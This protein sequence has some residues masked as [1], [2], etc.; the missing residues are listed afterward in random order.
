ML[1]L[2]DAHRLYFSWRAMVEFGKL[3][4]EMPVSPCLT[5][6]DQHE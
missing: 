5:H 4:I 3:R 2:K 6:P 1:I